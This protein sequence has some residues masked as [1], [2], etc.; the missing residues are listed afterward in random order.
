MPSF[1]LHSWH[2]SC[3][4]IPCCL[5]V[6]LHAQHTPEKEAQGGDFRWPWVNT[7]HTLIVESTIHQQA[8]SH[9]MIRWG[10]IQL[11]R[12][13]H[14]PV[15]YFRVG[16]NKN[17]WSYNTNI[18][19]I[20][21]IIYAFDLYLVW[22]ITSKIVFG[23]PYTLPKRIL[24]HDNYPNCCPEIKKVI[25][26][27][28]SYLFFFFLAHSAYGNATLFRIRIWHGTLSGMG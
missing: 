4:T 22:S 28:F 20:Y 14:V 19:M 9:C 7:T 11:Q 8:L 27:I 18:M 13:P 5:L 23:N 6:A 15:L 25:I 21:L 2:G 17:D 3:L 10:I 16:Q 26:L 1:Q 12:S 24:R